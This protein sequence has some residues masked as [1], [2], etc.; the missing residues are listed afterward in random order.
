MKDVSEG[1]R[2][3]GEDKEIER[4]RVRGEEKKGCV[5]LRGLA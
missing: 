1:V 4:E 3:L 5:R 2:E